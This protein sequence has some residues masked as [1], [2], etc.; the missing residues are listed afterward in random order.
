MIQS[1]RISSA[2]RRM[3]NVVTHASLPGGLRRFDTYRNAVSVLVPATALVTALITYSRINNRLIRSERP[4]NENDDD[5][6]SS[7]P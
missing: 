3:P 6:Y 7:L 1:S 5:W 2:V 4:W